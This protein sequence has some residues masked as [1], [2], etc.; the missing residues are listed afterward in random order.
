MPDDFTLQWREVQESMGLE[1]NNYFV[2][3]VYLPHLQFLMISSC[4]NFQLK[5]LNV[6]LHYKVRTIG[7]TSVL[8]WSSYM[9]ESDWHWDFSMSLDGVGA[10][11]LL[12]PWMKGVHKRQKKFTLFIEITPDALLKWQTQPERALEWCSQCTKTRSKAPEK[13]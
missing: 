9:Y 10:K 3:V 11:F 12:K 7:V 4:C 8:N 1:N 2:H 6:V 5:K 13:T